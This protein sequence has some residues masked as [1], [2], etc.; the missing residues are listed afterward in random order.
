MKKLR[1]QSE[2][3]QTNPGNENSG[4][5]NSKPN[6]NVNNINNNNNENS[7]RAE[8]QPKTVYTPCE[9]CDD[10][11]NELYITVSSAIVLKR[12][13][14]MLYFPLDFKNGLT[15]DALVDSEAYVSA[16][17][18][19]ELDI[20]K[21]EAPANTFKTDNLLN[22]QIQV[23]NG[24]LEKPMATATPNFVT[25]DHIFAQ[26]FVVLK[27]LTGPIVR[28]HFM[29]HN[30]VVIDTTH[31]LIHFPHLTMQVKSAL[32][33]T[34]AEPRAVLIHDSLTVPPMTK[35]TITDFVDHLSEWN[36]TGTVTPVEKFTEARV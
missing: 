4:A 11:S 23:A 15:I 30:N 33:G 29:R 3:T 5:N 13:N 8:R 36:R 21:P 24:Q 26:H 6:S 35:K 34:S 22:F 9:T 27:N 31:D 2:D 16:I 14:E 18:E 1:A 20:F 12:K 32:S 10:N 17:A 28:V 25:G 7:N 19:K